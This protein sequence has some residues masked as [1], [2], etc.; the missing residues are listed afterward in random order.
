MADKAQGA[1]SGAAGGAALGTA[2]APGYGT[3]IGAVAGGLYGLFSTPDDYTSPSFS[4]INLQSEN[5]ELYAQL[6]QLRA[7]QSQAQR[8]YDTRRM[9]MTAQEESDYYKGMANSRDVQSSQGLLGTSVG[10]SQMTN[11]N[12]LLRGAIADRA[13]KEREQ[14]FGNLQSATQNNFNGTNQ[15][16]QEIMAL[17]SGA[18]QM[19]YNQGLQQ[20]QG[21]TA[22]IQSGLNAYQTANNNDQNNQFRQQL[23]NQSPFAGYG[24][25]GGYGNPYAPVPQSNFSQPQMNPYSQGVPGYGYQRANLGSYTY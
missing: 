11:T 23:L 22:F 16:L 14:L 24:G 18:G 1:I 15:A 4:D 21:N 17:K 7:I 5:P 10:N 12:N 3:A 13:L 25:P 20:T 19:N 9:G 8:E 6:L 2:I